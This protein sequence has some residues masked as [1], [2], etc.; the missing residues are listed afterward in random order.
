MKRLLIAVFSVCMALALTLYAGFRWVVPRLERA[1]IAGKM[2]R[3]SVATVVGKEQIKLKDGQ[4][5]TFP[6]GSDVV[7]PLNVFL[8]RYRIDDFQGITDAEREAVLRSERKRYAKDGPRVKE[9]DQSE[10]DSLEIGAQIAVKY[11]YYPGALWGISD[12]IR[13]PW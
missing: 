1:V 5:F 4:V 11:A 3:T 6:N 8:V 12:S 2:P 7:G 10:Y 13:V 9:V